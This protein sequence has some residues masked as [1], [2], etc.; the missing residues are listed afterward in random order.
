MSRGKSACREEEE[1][2]IE[3]TVFRAEWRGLVRADPEGGG[4]GRLLDQGK[5]GA[6]WAGFGF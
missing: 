5:G 1:Q 6:F 4:F 2:C 3:G